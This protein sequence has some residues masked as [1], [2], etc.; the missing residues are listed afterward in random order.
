M[1]YSHHRHSQPTCL[2]ERQLLCALCVRWPTICA[3][4]ASPFRS[5]RIRRPRGA[6]T[7]ATRGEDRWLRVVWIG[8][9][10]W[11]TGLSIR[12]QASGG[13]SVEPCAGRKK[14]AEEALARLRLDVRSGT[15]LVGT[16]GRTMRA[17]CDLYVRDARTEMNTL[18]TDRSAQSSMRDTSG[19][20]VAHG[21][22]NAGQG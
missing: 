14:N 8:G 10:S 21:P 13:D 12:S 15:V 11:W 9:L 18:R 2:A 22:R 5:G 17:A 6:V 4:E 7:V 20:P 1:L 16:N 19:G 3:R